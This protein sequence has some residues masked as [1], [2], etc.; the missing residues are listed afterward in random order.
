MFELQESAILF[1]ILR[2]N[3]FEF[4]ML[5]VLQH[6][7]IRICMN[8]LSKK[9]PRYYWLLIK[10]QVHMFVIWSVLLDII[11][12]SVTQSFIWMIITV[13]LS[14][15]RKTCSYQF[16][17]RSSLLELF[18][19]KV[20]LENFAKLAGKHLCRSLFVINLQAYLI[21]KRLRHRSFSVNFAKFLRTPISTKHFRWLLLDVLNAADQCG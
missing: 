15:F 17:F 3:R 8:V 2:G 18:R 6:F 4:K 11:W 13:K 19:K 16:I 10:M 12:R 5:N 14:L 21:K 9:L 20:F 1:T 7:L